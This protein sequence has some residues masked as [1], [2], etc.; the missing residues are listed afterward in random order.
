MQAD[1]FADHFPARPPLAKSSAWD[2]HLPTA[3]IL[4]TRVKREP[5]ARFC[6]HEQRAIIE[7]SETRARARA[8][9][10][11]HAINVNFAMLTQERELARH[12]FNDNHIK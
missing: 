11:R 5:N 3:Q 12:P 4:W 1:H 10:F 2:F 6:S 7:R 9:Q 8:L